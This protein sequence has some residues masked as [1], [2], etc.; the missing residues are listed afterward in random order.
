MPRVRRPSP[1]RLSAPPAAVRAA[2]I[3]E[4]DAT[5]L[6]DDTVRVPVADRALIDVAVDLTLTTAPDDGTKP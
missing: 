5:E 3:A 1:V 4:L 6:G 2:A